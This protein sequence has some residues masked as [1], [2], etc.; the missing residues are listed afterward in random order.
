VDRRLWPSVT[1]P[2]E[3]FDRLATENT[4]S[5][6]EVAGMRPSMARRTF[7]LGRMDRAERRVIANV[8]PAVTLKSG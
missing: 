4:P 5:P 6:A 2:E 7:D 8:R 3:D 1:A